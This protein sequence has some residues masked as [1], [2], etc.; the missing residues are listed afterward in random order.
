M[1]MPWQT[2]QDGGQIGPPMVAML[3]L[4]LAAVTRLPGLDT[5]PLWTDELISWVLATRETAAALVA[6]AADQLWP[7]VH[8]LIQRA[9]L[10]AFDP[11]DGAAF[12]LRL[13]TAVG[14]IAAV[15]LI[16]WGGRRLVGAWP[17]ALA[18]MLLAL[19]A[20]QIDKCTEIGQVGYRT[21]QM[22]ARTDFFKQ[23]LAIFSFD[24]GR[25]FRKDK[26]VCFGIQF[27]DF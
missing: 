12:W 15:G 21:I 11:V 13:P 20:A 25:P 19:S 10:L 14:G 22:I 27:D 3:A 6:A 9:T 4:M 26:A 24:T 5:A 1:T 16:Y 8:Y 17:A 7:P 18:A 23:L 2:D